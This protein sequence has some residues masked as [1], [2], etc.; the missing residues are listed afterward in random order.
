MRLSSAVLLRAPSSLRAL[1]LTLAA[2]AP[3]TEGRSQA[4]LSRGE[5]SVTVYVVLDGEPAV[6]AHD[7][8]ARLAEL[9]VE[10]ARLRPELESHGGRVLGELSR[11][12]NAFI[13][14]VPESELARIEELPGVHHV[15]EV[16]IMEQTLA[17]A[18]PLIGA[19]KLWSVPYD[20]TG[21]TIGIVDTGVDYTHSDL[22]GS[23]NPADYQSNDRAL[24]EAGTFPTARVVGGWDFAGDN[25]DAS[26]PSLDTPAPDPDPLDCGGHGSHVSG[27]AAGN[28]VLP[29]GSAFTGPYE[30]SLD[31]TALK[32]A[33]GVAPRAS[34]FALKVFGCGGSTALSSLAFDRAADPNE[35]GDFS[36][37]LDVVNASLGASY[38]PSSGVTASIIENL[39]AVGTVLVAASG[40]D[41]NN[42]FITATPGN[43]KNAI[44]VAASFDALFVTLRVDVP[45][46]IAGDYPAT[47]GAFTAPLTQ[48]GPVSG[49][50]SA[51]DPAQACE[52]IANDVS[53]SIV[54]IDRGGCAFID[55]FARA[56]EAGAIAVVMVDHET[57]QPPFVMG[58]SVSSPL[59]GVMIRRVDGDML[60]VLSGVEIT[61]SPERYTGLGSELW[62]SFSSR[63]PSSLGGVLKPEVTAPGVDIQS[64]EVGSGSGIRTSQGTSM[65]TPLVSGAAALLRQV[66]PALTPR[67]IKALLMN[68]AQPVVDAKGRPMPISMQGAGRIDVAEAA[69]RTVRA[70]VDENDGSVAVSF[71]ALVVDEPTTFERLV[72]VENSGALAVSFAAAIEPFHALSGVELTTDPATFMVPAGG[73]VQVKIVLDVDPAALG[74]P[75]PD[76]LTPPT[77]FELPRHHLSEAA[78]RLLLVD[79]LGAQSI[80]LPYYA[81]VRAAARRRA[82]LPYA[83]PDDSQGERLVMPIEGESAHPDPVTSAFELGGI[84]E[85]D[86]N[87]DNPSLDILAFGVA[88]DAARYDDVAEASLYFGVATAAPWST[89][90]QAVYS[91]VAVEID[92]DQNGGADFRTMAEPY[93]REE[94][95]GDVLVATTYDLSTGEQA[96]SKRFLNMASA[97][98]ASTQP[99]FN[100]VL[101]FPV[102]ARDI[103]LSERDSRF[104]YRLVSIAPFVGQY[105]DDTDW[106]TFDAR[107]PRLDTTPLGAPGRPLYRSGDLVSLRIDRS[108]PDPPSLLLLHHSNIPSERFEV[109]EVESFESELAAVSADAPAA[110]GPGERGVIHVA[111]VNEGTHPLVDAELE[112]TLSGASLD[113][114]APSDGSCERGD[115][116][117]CTFGTLEPGARVEVGLHVVAGAD[118]NVSV[119]LRLTSAS[120]C[121]HEQRVQVAPRQDPIVAPLDPGG[122]CGCRVSSRDERWGLALA[123]VA[124]LVRRRRYRG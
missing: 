69:A 96:G 28:G 73:V 19:P 79:A 111:V 91:V 66:N 86:P 14:R 93:R 87:Q 23:G 55:K 21:T 123:L 16:P 59:P 100:S 63:G 118:A 90:A 8:R 101:V 64:A 71:G 7:P 15:E 78:G 77:Q 122:G 35:D 62:A 18:V 34:I 106:V 67:Q 5:E 94:P 9:A 26:N 58:G 51:A 10:R 98:E 12:A 44:S 74:A 25:Y 50:L 32:I 76:P 41:G 31:L 1:F 88:A 54:V 84:D 4:R 27:I 52:A 83:C 81:S 33:P 30:Q 97:A 57:D 56:E 68:T 6:R 124:L 60:K 108:L 120:G 92:A 114:A 80:A 46:A 89:P 107:E 95:F 113:I 75:A 49:T 2:C 85:T 29:S 39:T 40:N 115:E 72:N 116:V 61:L 11:V 112:G 82:A 48:T 24:I 109:L 47:E 117:R 99:Y 20:G 102:F 13:L 42:F 43:D 17:S 37:R 121:T 70:L 65:A 38:G 104:N 22:G 110:L 119:D 3:S 45:D 53:G 105:A 103:G 36:D